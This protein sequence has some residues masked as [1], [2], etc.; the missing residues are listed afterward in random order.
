MKELVQTYFQVGIIVA[1]AFPSYAENPVKAIEK[2]AQDADFDAI[3]LNPIADPQMRAKA[4]SLLAQSHMTVSYG[5]HGKLLGAG[6]NPNDLEETGRQKAQE[7]LFSGI[8]EAEEI[9][10][11]RVTFLSGHW[12][13]QTRMQ[14]LEQLYKTTVAICQYAA[15]K[16]M[17]IELEV[18]DYDIAKCCLL[19][20]SALAAEFAARVRESCPNFGLMVDLSHF[21]MCHESTQ[22]VIR[23]LRPYITHF[24]IGNTVINP[25]QAAYGDEHPRFG[26]PYSEND[27]PQLLS[28][29]RVLREE[30]F[31]E[32]AAPYILSFEVKP[33]QDE[34]AEIVIANAKRVFSRAWSIL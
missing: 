18:F 17:C 32:A 9:G 10:A 13:E 16:D 7:A 31:F 2:I 14:S 22:F 11:K 3:E 34:T 1:M 26:F 4:A 19:G 5:A 8:D 29:L 21:P 27:M 23:T 25:A 30:G 15:Q 28:F 33:W 24:H 6:L 12:Q 20:P